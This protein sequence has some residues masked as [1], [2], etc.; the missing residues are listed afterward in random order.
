MTQI[1]E[2]LERLK[3]IKDNTDTLGDGQA[4]YMDDMTEAEYADY[5]HQ[6]ENG[7]GKVYKK[8]KELL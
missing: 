8:L 2:L 4:V 6:E 3:K 1:M 7:W 5:Q